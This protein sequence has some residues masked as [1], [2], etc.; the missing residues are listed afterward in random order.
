MS[1]SRVPMPL[2][3][4]RQGRRLCSS[5]TQSGRHDHRRPGRRRR[6]VGVRR[7][8]AS[9]PGKARSPASLME[10]ACRLEWDRAAAAFGCRPLPGAAFTEI[11]AIAAADRRLRRSSSPAGGVGG[12]EGAVW[13]ALE[14]QRGG[15][16][17][18]ADELMREVCREGRDLS[19]DRAQP[20]FPLAANLMQ[21]RSFNPTFRTFISNIN[22]F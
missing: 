2:D 11:D 1:S 19:Y 12:A 22:N 17:T 14:R 21:I 5:A 7:M 3:P 4:A 8:P 15:R 10:L 18:A 6:A 20:R 9:G 13:L 16:W